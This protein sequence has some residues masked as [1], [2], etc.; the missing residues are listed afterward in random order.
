MSS[1]V[2]ELI[3]KTAESLDITVDLLN[4]LAEVGSQIS[5]KKDFHSVMEELSKALDEG[6]LES[7]VL[8]LLALGAV[9]TGAELN[10]L[11]GS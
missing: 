11:G 5:Y 7:V 9:K 1:G 4:K 10:S 6:E 3:R 8:S 2:E